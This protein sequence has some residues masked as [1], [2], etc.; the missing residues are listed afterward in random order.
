MRGILSFANPIAVLRALV[1]VFLTK[2]M[3][4][5]NLAQVMMVDAI[6]QVSAL[7]ILFRDVF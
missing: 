7:V 3:G 4:S 2:P 6:N 5:R 1:N